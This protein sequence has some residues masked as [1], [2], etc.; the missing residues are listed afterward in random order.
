MGDSE[1]TGNNW[2]KKRDWM[3]WKSQRNS[4]FSWKMRHGMLKSHL[5]ELKEGMANVILG[6]LEFIQVTDL[7]ESAA[8]IRKTLAQ[9]E[10]IMK[11]TRCRDVLYKSNGML[12]LR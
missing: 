1:V 4:S 12:G 11:K 7:E 6:I 9:R 8:Q 3:T 2:N 10:E 5:R